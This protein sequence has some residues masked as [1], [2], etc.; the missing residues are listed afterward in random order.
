MSTSLL[1]RSDDCAPPIT[2]QWSSLSQSVW[3]HAMES[4]QVSNSQ[5]AV[6][7]CCRSFPGWLGMMILRSGSALCSLLL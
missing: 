1:I 6:S 4:M 3:L 5:C 7:G 2:C